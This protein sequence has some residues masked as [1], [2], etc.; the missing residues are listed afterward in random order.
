[1]LEVVDRLIGVWGAGRVGVHIAPRGD[2]HDMGDS[3][4]LGTFTYVARELGRRKIAF[5]AAREHI[6]DGRIGP[7]IKKAFGGVYV[8]NEGFTPELAEQALAKGEADAVAFGKLFIA[9]PDLPAR[10]AKKAALNPWRT[11]TFYHGGPDGY[12]DYP[13]LTQEPAFA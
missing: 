9:N 5:I 4:R 6:G 13:S 8:A 1:M 2:S 7:E 3:D 12:A 11:E 10:I